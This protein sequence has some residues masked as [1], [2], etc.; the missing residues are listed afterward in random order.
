M[1]NDLTSAM[2]KQHF[3]QFQQSQQS[4]QSRRLSP[5]PEEDETPCPP[6]K[7]RTRRRN[8]EVRK[9]SIY[10]KQY[11]PSEDDAWSK[12]VTSPRFKNM[13]KKEL[14]EQE[15]QQ[16][17]DVFPCAMCHREK[18]CLRKIVLSDQQ[19]CQLGFLAIDIR[20]RLETVKTTGDN[21]L[22]EA[23]K[24]LVYPFC[25]YDCEKMAFARSRS[26]RQNG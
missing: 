25:N 10:L 23:L 4:Q 7:R 16:F 24:A 3:Q 5:I 8:T 2:F 14:V 21:K 22:D 17:I 18:P 6:P 11:R 9:T 12:V 20:N 15:N 26:I 19:W 13:R 1:P